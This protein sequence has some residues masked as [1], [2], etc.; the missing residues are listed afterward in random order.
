MIT[1]KPYAAVPVTNTD[2]AGI[3]KLNAVMACVRTSWGIMQ[4][5][6]VLLKNRTSVICDSLSANAHSSI[7][8]Q[9]RGEDKQ[10]TVQCMQ[11]AAMNDLSDLPVTCQGT[12]R[13]D[14]VGFVRACMC[15]TE[16]AA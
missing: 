13:Q 15:Y 5:V 9:V 8:E 16:K 1:A 11:S 3:R 10:G 2:P 4:D 7:Y 6:H 12:A 14:D